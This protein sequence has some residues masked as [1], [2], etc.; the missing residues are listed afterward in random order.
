MLTVSEN[1]DR[2]ENDD[3]LQFTVRETA[4]IRDTLRSAAERRDVVRA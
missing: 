3:G 1:S 4:T 2:T